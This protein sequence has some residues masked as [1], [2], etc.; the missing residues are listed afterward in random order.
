METSTIDVS[1]KPRI[2]PDNNRKTI[3][4]EI[5]GAAIFSAL[6]IVLSVFLPPFRL[7]WGIAYFDPVSI[8][9]ITSFLIFGFR[10]GILTSIIGTVG[11]ILVDPYLAY[12]GPFMKFLSTIWFVLI[13]YLYIRLIKKSI[14]SGK[15]LKKLSNYI[16]S[17]LISWLVRCILMSILN[18]LIITYMF[19]MQVDLGW[20]G[21]SELT[22]NLAILQF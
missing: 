20:L 3:T 1:E 21:F 11:L 22:G 16:P 6:S 14:F 15:E 13:P 9:W 18:Y 12:F 19:E 4:I 8:I 10:A 7:A 5:V 2:V 17:M